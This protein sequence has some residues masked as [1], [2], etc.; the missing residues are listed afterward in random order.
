MLIDVHF[1]PEK[2]KKKKLY[3]ILRSRPAEQEE[4]NNS[5]SNMFLLIFL[6][7]PAT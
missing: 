6:S 4:F 3:R 5:D 1:R 7:S 2:K